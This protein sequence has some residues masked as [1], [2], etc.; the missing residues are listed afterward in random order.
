[1]LLSADAR[2]NTASSGWRW[3]VTATGA[4]RWCWSPEP[5]V[6]GRGIAS[7]RSAGWSVWWRPVARSRPA[8]A[9]EVTAAGGT[10]PSWTCDVTTAI[11]ARRGAVVDRRPTQ[12]GGAQRHQRALARTGGPSR[13]PMDHLGHWWSPCAALLCHT[14]T[15]IWWPV[16]QP[17]AADLRGRFGAPCGWRPTPP[18]RSRRA[19]PVM[20]GSGVGTRA[21]NA[22][23]W[24]SH[25]G[26]VHGRDPTWRSG[27][28]SPPLGRW[29]V[30][31]TTWDR[32]PVLLSDEAGYVTGY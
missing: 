12:R 13:G 22:W 4:G 27:A 19:C 28:R 30:R 1:M 7:L 23:P 24:R 32:C 21:R 17:G 6:R 25:R 2:V 15:P 8:V 9:E 5:A 10:A 16:G 20:A 31:W 18:S 29:A 3:L 14:P 26:Y 11:G